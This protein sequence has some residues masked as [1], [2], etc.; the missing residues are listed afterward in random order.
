MNSEQKIDQKEETR[1]KYICFY[2]DEQIGE[3]TK[4]TYIDEKHVIY[5]IYEG[6]DS[7]F[8]G[9]KAGAEWQIIGTTVIID[10]KKYVATCNMKDALHIDTFRNLMWKDNLIVGMYDSKY[11]T[12]KEKEE[13]K[14]YALS[15]YLNEKS[16]QLIK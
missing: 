16:Y 6:I 9:M 3:F 14:D 15:Y 10:N 8:V 13:I 1:G 11:V 5:E 4:K 2:D 7:T 12:Q